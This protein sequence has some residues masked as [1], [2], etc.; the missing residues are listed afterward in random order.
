MD[1]FEEG[2]FKIYRVFIENS[3]R[4][5][6]YVIACK[7]TNECAVIDPLDAREIL[8]LIRNENLTIRY[9]INT[10]AHPDHIE[11]NNAVIKV[12]MISKILIHPDGLDYVAPRAQA[13]NDGDTIKLGTN[14]I[15]VLHTPGH[16][17]EHISLLIDSYIFVGDTVFYSGCGNT[18]F[19][20]NPGDLY[21]SIHM[22]IAELPDSTRILCG[23][24]Y[25]E[26]NLQFALSVDPENNE[27]NKKIQEVNFNLSRNKFPLSTIGEEK[28][29][30]PFFRLNESS[31]VD[32]LKA[33]HSFRSDDEKSVFIKLRELRNNW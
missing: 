30:N 32:N 2:N 28:T 23:H 5:F 16:C 33:E 10:H 29:Y 26:N 17:P 31:I 20:G 7:D 18:K 9:V 11:G 25:S 27:I 22:K 1:I 12:S 13:I 14:E 4:N 24:E 3:G 8:Y 19:R 6:N 15:K 21:S